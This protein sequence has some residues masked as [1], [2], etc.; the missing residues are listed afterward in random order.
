MTT[1][2]VGSSEESVRHDDDLTA[3]PTTA[4]PT[5]DAETRMAP[6]AFR[7]GVERIRKA[8]RQARRPAERPVTRTDNL[9]DD[10]IE[11]NPSI[12]SRARIFQGPEWDPSRQAHR[13][14]WLRWK[15]L[16]F[17]D[18]VLAW[19]KIKLSFAIFLSRRAIDRPLAY[20]VIVGASVVGGVFIVWAAP[21]VSGVGAVVV[22]LIAMCLFLKLVRIGLDYADWARAREAGA[23]GDTDRDAEPD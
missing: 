21:T 6:S 3:Y 2:G 19:D 16:T 5:D 22:W 10:V 18:A 11:A 12:T 14:G 15:H 7:A 17:V 8:T 20:G 23:S 13:R 1:D 4:H 9:A